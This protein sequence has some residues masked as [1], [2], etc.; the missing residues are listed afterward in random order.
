MFQNS[1][2]NHNLICVCILAPNVRGCKTRFKSRLTPVNPIS[3]MIV[4]EV[5]GF[6]G[7]TGWYLGGHRH[8]YTDMRN[9]DSTYAIV[10][11]PA[12]LDANAADLTHQEACKGDFIFEPGTL[13][14]TF[15]IKLVTTTTTATTAPPPPN[16]PVGWYLDAHRGDAE[17]RN[18]Q[19]T[20]AVFQNEPSVSAN[21]YVRLDPSLFMYA[22]LTAVAAVHCSLHAVWYVAPL[23]W[24]S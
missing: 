13:P 15:K 23:S 2:K 21:I 18:P 5:S 24:C 12:V 4:I 10:H 3:F 20:Y 7:T 22:G 1:A 11:S 9:D 19:S 14:G 16:Q 17:T 6:T 8:L